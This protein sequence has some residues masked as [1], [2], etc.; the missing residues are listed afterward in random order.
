MKLTSYP[1]SKYR[2]QA[3]KIEFASGQLLEKVKKQTPIWGQ[4]P[5]FGCTE[6][7]KC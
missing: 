1:K 6:E 3:S 2:L 4:N 5:Y 7:V